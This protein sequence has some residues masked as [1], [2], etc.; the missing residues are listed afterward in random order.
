M[1][2]MLPTS[3]QPVASVGDDVRAACYARATPT[4]LC[5]PDDRQ[6]LDR[7][8]DHPDWICQLLSQWT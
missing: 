8:L 7:P 3:L 4:T 5:M 6:E 2:S 1:A